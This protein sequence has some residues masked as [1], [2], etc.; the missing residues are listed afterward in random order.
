MMSWKK[1]KFRDRNQISGCGEWRS[2]Q[3]AGGNL[4]ND[5][6]VLCLDCGIITRPGQSSSNC[7]PKK[8]EFYCMQIIPQ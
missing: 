2:G 8:G 7:V 4:E 3:G 6:A 5:G 1:H